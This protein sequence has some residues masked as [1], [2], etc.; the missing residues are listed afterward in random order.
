MLCTITG[1][2][3]K[4]IREY[5]LLPR[6]NDYILKYTTYQHAP[7]VE[8]PVKKASTRRSNESRS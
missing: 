7:S 1:S 8:S 2:N 6:N 3:L 4:P 5:S